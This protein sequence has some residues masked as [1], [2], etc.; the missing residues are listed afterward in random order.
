MEP[1]WSISRAP[2]EDDAELRILTEHVIPKRS[3]FT[4]TPRPT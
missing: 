1:A 3:R 4:A 2:L